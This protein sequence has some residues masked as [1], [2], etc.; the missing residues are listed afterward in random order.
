M[1][2]KKKK[3]REERERRRENGKSW[4]NKGLFGARRSHFCRDV[5][6]GSRRL[7]EHPDE[8]RNEEQELKDLKEDQL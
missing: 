2:K 1:G 8:G 7:R 5:L 4:M 3:K 6:Q